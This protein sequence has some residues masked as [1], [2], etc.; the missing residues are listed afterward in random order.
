M[1]IVH[2]A[3]NQA[4]RSITSAVCRIDR[5]PFRSFPHRG[6]LIVVFNHI[7]SIE[8]PLLLAHLQPRRVVGLAKV[9]TWDSPLMAWLFDQWDAIPV[10]RGE[11]DLEAMRCCLQVLDAGD[12]LAI[13]PEGTRS[14][15]GRLLRGQPGVVTLALRSGAPILPAAHWGVEDFRRNL[16]RF[17]RTGFHIRT[18]EP[19]RVDTNGEKVSGEVRQQIADEIMCQIAC[20]LPEAYRGEYPAERCHPPKYLKPV[21]DR[22]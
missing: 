19:F 9:E 4:I 3:V 14:R 21:A 18:G 2:W 17:K 20:L 5:E 13:A 22:H 1:P 8:V 15:H 7:G 16:S 12:I 6:P 11:A 10:R